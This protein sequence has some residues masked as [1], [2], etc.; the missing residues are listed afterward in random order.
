L[1]NLRR[2]WM[3]HK[4][5]RCWCLQSSSSAPSPRLVCSAPRKSCQL[6]ATSATI[7]DHSAVSHGVNRVYFRRRGTWT[8]RRE[9]RGGGLAM[10]QW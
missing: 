2:Q 10:A 9:E 3:D 5:R 4:G 1:E 7:A 8:L 6:E